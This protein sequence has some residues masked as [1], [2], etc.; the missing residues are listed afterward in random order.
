MKIALVLPGGVDR[1]GSERVIPCLLWLIER[2]TA[3]GDA[4]HVFALHQEPEPGRWSLLGA[5]VHNAGRRPKRLRSLAALAAEHRRSPFDLIHGFW[6]AGPGVVAGLFGRAARLPVVLSMPGGDLSALHDI[7]YGARVTARGRAWTRLAIA[8]ADR[9]VVPSRHIAEEA[10]IL[11]IASEVIPFGV[12][13]DRWHPAPPRRRTGGTLRLIQ[14]A[15]LNRVKDQGT[16]LEALRLLRECGADFHL[17]L[18]GCDT[19]GGTVQRRCQAL[20]LDRHVSFHGF[21]PNRELRAYLERSDLMLL[22]SRHEAGPI[23]MVEAAMVGVPTVGTKVGLIDDWA[24]DA[25]VAVPVGDAVAIADAVVRLA[26]DESERLRLAD[27]AQCRALAK[28][29][30]D[31]ARRFRALYAEVIVRRSR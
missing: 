27:A 31:T 19:L 30:D 12:A 1:S 20:G 13:R 4:V 28:D 16:L 6:A 3:A 9:E 22:S 25:A 29:A 15:S 17:D 5:E 8:C 21:L 23:V 10:S 24:P 18:I 7:G 11:G 26:D 14:I 2:L